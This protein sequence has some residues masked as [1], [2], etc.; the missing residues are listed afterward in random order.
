MRI[1]SNHRPGKQ[2]AA[3]YKKTSVPDFPAPMRA[4]FQI[5]IPRLPRR[6]RPAKQAVT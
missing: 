3:P 2:A 1:A 5:V 6:A 4:C